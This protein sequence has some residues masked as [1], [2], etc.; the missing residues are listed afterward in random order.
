MV[1]SHGDDRRTRYVPNW[2]SHLTYDASPMDTDPLTITEPDMLDL[3]RATFSAWI[4]EC[5]ECGR[6]DLAG[7]L[8]THND[9]QFLCTACAN[10]YRAAWA[11]WL[12][13]ARY[14]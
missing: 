8:V 4:T 9:G 1:I 2:S 12:R 13:Q 11:D 5:A 6:V 10:E 14:S 7:N 3:E